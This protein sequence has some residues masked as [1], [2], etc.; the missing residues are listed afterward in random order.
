[1]LFLVLI[2]LIWMTR[3]PAGHAGGAEAAGAH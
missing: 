1:V 3:R 2:V